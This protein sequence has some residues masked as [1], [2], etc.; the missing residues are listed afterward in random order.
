MRDPFIQFL[1]RKIDIELQ[2][3]MAQIKRDRK[4]KELSKKTFATQKRQDK[5]GKKG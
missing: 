2:E 5:E 4:E 1:F 3:T